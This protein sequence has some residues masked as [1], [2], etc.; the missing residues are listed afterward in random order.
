MNLE[1][2]PSLED[3][4][5]ARRLTGSARVRSV[6]V[7]QPKRIAIIGGGLV[8]AL[9]ACFFAQKGFLVD[10]YEYR[11]DIRSTEKA[12]GR[13]INLA[14]S[15]RGRAALKAV[16]LED[17]VVSEGIPMRAR[18]IHDTNES[19]HEVPYG[20]F[21]DQ[22]IISIDRRRLNEVMLSLAEKY[23]ELVTLHF[24]HKLIKVDLYSG[25][26]KFVTED[27]STVERS[28]DLVM[29]CDG[30]YSA[31]RQA[32]M[33]Q[34]LFDYSQEFIEHGYIELE[35]PPNGCGEYAMPP[36]FLHI[37]PRDTFMLIALP[38]LDHSF[39]TT[40]FMP[41]RKFEELTTEAQV[42]AFFRDT[43]P[44]ALKII[45]ESNLVQSFLSTKPSSLISIKCKPYHV[46]RTVIL[47]DAAH[48]M[49][50]FYGQGMNAGF[51]DCLVFHELMDSLDC[52]IDLVLPAFTERMLPNSHA[53]IDLAMYNYIE[54][55][56]LVN[57]WSYYLRKK[58]DNTLYR[59]FPGTWVPLYTM[60][61][62][63]M[64]PYAE[65]VENRAWQDKV[66]RRAKWV[67][68][69]STIAV[70]L[71]WFFPRPTV[72]DYIVGFKEA[73]NT[74]FRNVKVDRFYVTAED[75]NF[76]TAGAWY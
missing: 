65:C 26:M 10:V 39:T 27:G 62:F 19:T 61:T 48:A 15:F 59:L 7:G 50:P 28:A 74:W 53:I 23:K 17:Y 55:R 71:Y 14:L 42:L 57:T 25:A 60:V 66:L 58:I 11:A 30:A 1:A 38:N 37:W 35:T 56:H 8:G 52:D 16:G 33:K 3:A 4:E 12:V 24:H 44:D 64:T 32:M 40:L 76:G 51:L 45:G 73:L 22:F 18:M 31:V 29:G 75:P 41:F 6:H 21:P 54:M 36:N 9:N 20:I 49:V 34:S 70:G 68:G 5:S 47:G 46:G 72:N 13:S 67:I 69:I 63:S 2:E 43:F